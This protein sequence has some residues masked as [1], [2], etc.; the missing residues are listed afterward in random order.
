MHT[1]TERR[2]V[3]TTR[4]RPGTAMRYDTSSAGNI[5]N[6]A[7]QSMMGGDRSSGS[8]VDE[9]GARI[10]Q[11]LP[12]VQQRAQAQIPRAENEADRLSAAINAGTPETVK[13]MM[14]QRMGADFS[15]VRFHTGAAAAAKA[16]A[17]GARAYTSG[18]D[19]YFGSGG[20]DPSVAAHELVHTAQQGMVDSG[21]SVMST[22]V[23]GVQMKPGF[24]SRLFGR[25]KKKNRIDLAAPM[26]RSRKTRA[27]GD[28]AANLMAGDT[29]IE[30]EYDALMADIAAEEGEEK[31]AV[32]KA[33][34]NQEMNQNKS[35]E[36]V[37]QQIREL[38]KVAE[39]GPA[40]SGIDTELLRQ[41]LQEL[42]AQKEEL[43]A[44]SAD[45]A[46][47][48]KMADEDLA[49]KMEE[50]GDWADE[51][52]AL[53]AEE[54]EIEAFLA[55]AKH[56]P[57]LVD[58]AESLDLDDETIEA[59]AGAEYEAIMA[60]L[61]KEDEEK[62][63][64]NMSE[65][66]AGDLLEN[67]E[68]EAQQE[69]DDEWDDWEEEEE[70]VPKKKKKGFFSRMWSGAKKLVN[71]V[72]DTHD[73]VVR[74]AKKLVKKAWDKTGGRLI[75][76]HHDAM[77]Q[78]HEAM[79]S[80]EWDQLTPSEKKKW[81][82]KNPIAYKRYMGSDK[83]KAETALR[84]GKRKQEEE[85]AAEYLKAN[86]GNL[87]RSSMLTTQAP[88]TPGG[89]GKA[90]ASGKAGAPAKAG[91]PAKGTTPGGAGAAG[92]SLAIGR[93]RA[94]P[95]RVSESVSLEDRL[96]KWSGRIDNALIPPD[97]ANAME[98]ADWIS[99]AGGDAL[100]GIMGGINAATGGFGMYKSIKEIKEAFKNGGHMDR[101]D[102]FMDLFGNTAKTTGGMG[103]VADAFGKSVG[104][105][106]A[107]GAGIVTGSVDVYKGA[108]QIHAGRMKHNAM[109][110]FQKEFFGPIPRERLAD[111]DMLLR[112]IST[113]GKMEGTRQ[114]IKGAGK[115]V[116]GAADAAAG[117]CEL[118]GAGA[119]VGAGIKVG[120][121]AAKA[122]FAAANAAQKNRMVKKVTEQTTGLTDAKIRE[123]QKATGIKSFSRAKQALMKSMGYESG[124]RAELYADQ[125]EKR[126]Q[127]LAEQ[128]NSGTTDERVGQLV[129]GLGVKQKDDGSYD[130]EEIT[131]SLGH[132]KSRDEIASGSNSIKKMIQRRKINQANAAQ[133]KT[134]QT[135]AA[136]KKPAKKKTS[137]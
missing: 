95:A 6:S 14:G 28:A 42:V 127:Y 43:E 2:K 1:N 36:Q 16:D 69:L 90:G 39:G 107:A 96:D 5:P 37:N 71:K 38:M 104:G 123:F 89:P 97:V 22:P 51:A 20:F 32:Q 19:I 82:R 100:G 64:K 7:M 68:D 125:T 92:P 49:T 73:R 41:Q 80:G 52:N 75:R 25:K 31:A 132:W 134:A 103:S 114:K 99:N 136:Q 11:R 98:E 55:N 65:E 26:K 116:T 47:L 3:H 48:K 129:Q 122:G 119:A 15:G 93:G 27:I 67:M 9:L 70:Q 24:F 124:Q 121:A 12:A 30:D 33:P 87:G 130:A 120:S 76:K 35:A 63:E 18:A 60:E 34:R 110:Q 53:F 78:L 128:L 29:D 23:G 62:Q 66:E 113:Q 59:E 102:A 105:D 117:I 44:Q 45:I 101:L 4:S 57:A 58:D 109:E 54:D 137:R 133:T 56:R 111:H 108:R 91:G 8:S 10:L 115:V 84:I 50:S 72:C 112:D 126:G 46:K 131:K 61:M 17:M 83:V 81:I 94:D 21:M 88:S 74:G 85:A 118:S 135:K 86:Q 106:V 79:Q 13:A 77:D 40:K